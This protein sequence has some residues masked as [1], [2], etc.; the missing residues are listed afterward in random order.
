MVAENRESIEVDYL[1][2][3]DES[4]EQNIC[5]FLPEAPEQVSERLEM[6]EFLFKRTA[7]F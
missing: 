6:R 1:D 4:G 7:S 5:Y 3:A 2:L